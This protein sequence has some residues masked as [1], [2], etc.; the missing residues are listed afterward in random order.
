MRKTLTFIA[1]LWIAA[2][3][4]LRADGIIL[5]PVA[6]P[7]VFMPDQRALLVWRGGTETLVIESRFTGTGDHFAWVVPLPSKPE[8][9]PATSGA[10]PSL[11]AV[12]RPRIIEPVALGFLGPAIFL[13]LPVLLLFFFEASL[14]RL[15]Y[16][17][18]IAILLGSAA[19]FGGAG[20]I[21]NLA[22][23]RG[24][25][26]LAIPV[27][28]L[29]GLAWVL[30]RNPMRLVAAWG[31]TVLTLLL[32]AMAIPAFS[33]V[34]SMTGPMADGLTVEQQ[35]VGDYDVAVLS[36]PDAARL[37]D[38][39][40]QNG[41]ALPAAAAPVLAEHARSGGCFVA[42]KLRRDAAITK[43]QAPHPL[44]F[45]FKT[46]QPVY[47][48]KLTGTGI[49][50]SL[51]LDLYVF[52]DAVARVENLPLRAC[53]RVE[54]IAPSEKATATSKVSSTA[55]EE[56]R[57]RL[58]HTALREL[59]AGTTVATRLRGTLTPEQMRQ[60]L[61][62][63][64]RDFTGPRGLAKF[65]RSDAWGYA[66]LITLGSLLLGGGILFVCHRA[67]HASVRARLWV[68]GGACCIG[69]V[70]GFAF[71][72][73]AVENGRKHFVFRHE[74]RV[75]QYSLE[76]A[77]DGSDPLTVSEQQIRDRLTS[78]FASPDSELHRHFKNLPAY[79]DAPGQYHVRQLD[80]GGWQ[81]V[82]VDA[83]GQEHTT[84]R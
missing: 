71:P 45:T 82:L 74:A 17:R 55:P 57:L 2:V 3:T 4:S 59:C 14:A 39:L 16:S 21:E 34:R 30:W 29:A 41:F 66:A 20:L 40:A 25:G 12:F 37:A 75:L 43:T 26:L 19:L 67:K 65:T 15:I 1:I 33:K 32:A 81:V 44:V 63:R 36:G 68:V 10:L 70:S 72:T 27:V 28:I 35:I 23:N 22:Y 5:P 47:P 9:K 7:E 56:D 80:T 13:C 6:A 48:M 62:I 60:D 54:I 11:Q 79:G 69:L 61:A 38:W 58:S 8:I 42:T 18:A 84:D 73:T 50:T 24:S 76:T 83:F 31:M 78:D 52:G 77:F 64:W 49:R 46:T 53:V 51:D